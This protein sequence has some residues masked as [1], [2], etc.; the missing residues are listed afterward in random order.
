M[1]GFFRSYFL[2]HRIL[3]SKLN[4]LLSA[5]GLI[6]SQWMV[7]YY[8]KNQG[9]STLVDISNY[10]NVRKPV[11]TR[12]VQSLEEAGF[13][14]QIPSR[15]RREKIIQLTAS[16]EAVYGECRQLIDALERE[17]TRGLSDE[18]KDVTLR[19]VIKIRENIINIGGNKHA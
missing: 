18:E 6:Y 12:T 16:G 15:D 9:P 3:I 13:V 8:V 2:L 7:M 19:S 10:Y 17:V 14:C 1:Q 4:D 5:H 11:I